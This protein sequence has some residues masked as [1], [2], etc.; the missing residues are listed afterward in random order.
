[1]WK[2]A[3]VKVRDIDENDNEL[4]DA[5]QIF[6]V[7]DLDNDGVYETF[8]RSS[9]IDVESLKMAIADIERDGI[10]TWFYENG[11]FKW[12]PEKDAYNWGWTPGGGKD[13]L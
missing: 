7:Y 12:V 2:Y 11:T 13:G 6:E 5:C 1:M 9:L 8:S 10:N 4:T 3:Q